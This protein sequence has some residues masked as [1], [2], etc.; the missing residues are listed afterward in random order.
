[1]SNLYSEYLAAL[2]KEGFAVSFVSFLFFC[3]MW[4]MGYSIGV[5]YMIIVGN[6]YGDDD[7]ELKNIEE[8]I[9]T[10]NDQGPNN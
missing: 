3:V 4:S 6:V 1:M 8:M 5:I 7:E 2:K 9:A 10:M